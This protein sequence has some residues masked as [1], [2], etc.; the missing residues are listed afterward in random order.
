MTLD[1][2]RK[3]ADKVQKAIDKV[4]PIEKAEK[5]QKFA[6]TKGGKA[7]LIGIPALAVGGSLYG[8]S[9]KSD[10]KKK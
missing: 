5:I 7:A 2:A 3:K 8:I 6:K 9:K 4:L 10:K 1:E